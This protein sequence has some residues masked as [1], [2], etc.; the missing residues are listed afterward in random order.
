MSL[1]KWIGFGG[2][3][4]SGSGAAAPKGAADASPAELAK[5]SA[6]T[7]GECKRF[8]LENVRTSLSLPRSL[9]SFLAIAVSWSLTN[10]SCGTVVW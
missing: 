3:A 6:L 7:K 9:D 5:I 10:A 2:G 4:Q 8:G 1:A